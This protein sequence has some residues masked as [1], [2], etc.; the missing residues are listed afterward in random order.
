MKIIIVS[1][2]IFIN[3]LLLPA[4]VVSPGVMQ[5][6]YEEI[7]T[8]YKY[9]LVLVPEDKSKKI[10]C[11]TIFHKDNKW[12]MTYF[13]F[14]GR[15]YETWLASSNDLLKWEIKGK[16]LAFTDSTDWDDDQKAGYPSLQDPKWG[17]S[18]KLNIFDGKYWMPYFGGSSK[19]YERGLLS[20]GM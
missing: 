10:D 20:A 6:I 3:A 17:G 18:Y 14:D 16:V 19:G 8:P 7:K 2:L 4:Q 9:G 11:P 5:K 15:G 13:I 12:Y 1:I